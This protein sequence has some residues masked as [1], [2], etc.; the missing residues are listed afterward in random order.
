[1]L[2]KLTKFLVTNK[3]ETQPYEANMNKRQV[4]QVPM[5]HHRYVIL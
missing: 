2:G 3:L 4:R 1:M 5:R